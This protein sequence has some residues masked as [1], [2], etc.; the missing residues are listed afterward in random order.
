MIS[1]FY[2]SILWSVFMIVIFVICTIFCSLF[3][4]LESWS[5]VESVSVRE[6]I[7]LS[8]IKGKNYNH[9]CQSL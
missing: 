2:T 4:N 9:N 3:V 6:F 1:Q 5:N 8:K 7:N